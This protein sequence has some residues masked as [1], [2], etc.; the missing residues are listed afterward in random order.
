MND[1]VHPLPSRAFLRNLPGKLASL[2]LCGLLTA[3]QTLPT[4]TALPGKQEP[5]ALRII[6]LNDFHGNLRTPSLRVPVADSTQSGGLRFERAGG[7]E[8][9][10]ALV[11]KLKI[12]ASNSMVV[13][14]GDMVGATPLVSA[15][16]RD[17]PTIEAMGLVGVD[18]HAIGNHEF[19]SGIV[20][21]KR[22]RTGGCELNA[23]TGQPDCKGRPPYRGSAFEFLA[24][25]VLVNKATPGGDVETL[26]PPYVIRSF[27]GVKVAFVGMTLKGTPR[28]V[29]PDSV[30]GLTFAD[31]VET[32]QRLLP[33]LNAE[34]A[35]SVVVI[36]HEGG[37]QTGGVNE[38]VDFKGNIRAIAE[39][40]PDAVSLVV[41]AHTHRYYICE[42]AGKLVTSAGSYGTLLTEINLTLDRTTGLV[43][44]KAARNHVVSP[45]GP[46]DARLTELVDRYVALARPLENRVVARL[47]RE[48]NAVSLPSGESALGNLVADAQLAATVSPD[49]GG[50]VIAFNN[51]ASLRAPLIPDAEGNIAYGALFATQ[52]FQNDLVV[53]NLTGAQLKAVLEQQFGPTVGQR[54]R[55]LNSSLGLTYSWDAARPQGERILMETIKLNGAHISP[56]LQY[57]VAVNSFVAAGGDGYTVFQAGTERQVSVQDLEAVVEF[58]SRQSGPVDVGPLGARVTRLN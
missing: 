4:G 48:F 52:P 21:L 18:L 28:I 32:V 43:T 47:A 16:F 55:S 39:K 31:E 15:L 46:K 44:S 19:D 7:V 11:A 12:G 40:L 8:Q 2:T 10:A 57:R 51:S 33:K 17:E 49:R 22:L 26:F 1:S 14:A 35:K 30:K 37:E 3:C 34:G 42:V 9:L 13:S 45:D 29:R 27:D 41:S 5:V 38:C 58:L 50:A 53:M 6:A 20:N 56:E 25:N 24:A 54:V 23:K 36:I